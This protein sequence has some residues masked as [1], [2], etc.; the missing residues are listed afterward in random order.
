MTEINDT[1][2]QIKVISPFT[3]SIGD[4]RG[5]S[6][7]SREGIA[8]QTKKSVDMKFKTIEESLLA[9]YA[10]EKKELDLCDWEKIGRPELLHV[11]FNALL[12]FVEKHGG[13][14]ELNNEE[15]ANE[16]VALVKALNDEN[17]SQMAIE[18]AIK[19]DNIDEEIVRNVARF[20][21]AQISPVASFWGGIVAQEIVKFTG[22]FT[23]LSQWLHYEVF[24]TLPEK[25]VTRTLS[26]CRYDDVIAI[27]GVETQELLANVNTFLVGAGA[28]GCEY[29][30]MLSLLGMCCGKKGL[31]HVTDDD[32]IETSNLNR[33]FLFRYFF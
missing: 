6:E 20:A 29:I 11:V 8:E 15:Q 3:F 32:N 4:T 23:P 18:G 10:P 31:L 2:H 33:Q 22:K 16:L 13:L 5:Y 21:R 9:P 27:F 12:R 7:Y 24:E 19:L 14:P 1:I 30:K 17:K 25:P 26:N 28:L